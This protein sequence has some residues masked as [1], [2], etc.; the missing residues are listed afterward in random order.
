MKNTMEEFKNI[1]KLIFKFD[2][3]NGYYLL[4]ACFFDDKLT[5]KIETTIAELDSKNGEIPADDFLKILASAEI[6]RWEK[7][8][9]PNGSKIE[10]ATKWSLDLYTDDNHY[11]SK[12]E[13]GY[14]PYHYDEFIEALKLIDDEACYFK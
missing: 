1:T 5:Y 9:L 10:D 4:N 14:W 2:C 6:D 3:L 12:G 8:Y 11:L 7:D 13:E